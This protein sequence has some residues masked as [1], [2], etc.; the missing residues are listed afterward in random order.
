MGAPDEPLMAELDPFSLSST[1]P[2]GTVVLQLFSREVMFDQGTTKDHPLLPL[3]KKKKKN[4]LRVA[5]IT[6]KQT[7]TTLN[8]NVS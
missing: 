3:G 5:V 1:M 2:R 6:P 8:P 4:F 7:T